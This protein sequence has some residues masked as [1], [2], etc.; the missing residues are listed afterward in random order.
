MMKATIPLVNRYVNWI[1]NLVFVTHTA[2]PVEKSAS[3]NKEDLLQ[4]YESQHRVIL[5]IFRI[6]LA[7][8][9][10]FLVI[11]VSFTL[12]TVFDPLAPSWVAYMMVAV[13]MLL[14]YGLYRTIQEFKTYLRNY[15]AIYTRLRDSR[16]VQT[17]PGR[18]RKFESRVLSVLKPKEHG[19]WD[20][21]ICRNCDKAIELLTNTCEHCGHEHEELLIN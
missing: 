16:R 13:G 10:A 19:G 15:V 3:S 4:L 1:K 12:F 20:S 8:F 21:K 5:S 7:G 2:G 9:C 11:S 18:P 17:G 14:L 6:G